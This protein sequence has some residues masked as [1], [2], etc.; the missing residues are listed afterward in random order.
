MGCLVWS[1]LHK[2]YTKDF[3]AS[4]VEGSRFFLGARFTRPLQ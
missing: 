1:S 2:T 3:L 4:E